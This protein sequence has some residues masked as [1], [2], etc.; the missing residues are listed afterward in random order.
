[1]RNLTAR[2]LRSRWQRLRFWL[3]FAITLLTLAWAQFTPWQH[4]AQAQNVAISAPLSTQGSTIIDTKGQPV[5]LRGVNW[6]GIET[7]THTPHG[8]WARDYKDML[9]QIADLGYNVIR[10][11][12]SVQSLRSQSISGVDFSIGSNR[13]LQG[14][15]PLQVMDIVIREAERQGLFILLDS[16]RLND[17][18][19]PVLWYGDGFTEVDWI[20]TWKMLARR[21]QNQKNVIGA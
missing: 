10:L 13:D 1:M 17:Q 8:L 6:F 5:L 7:D 14:K 20:D 2:T 12:Y 19:I 16:H 4:P 21:Y 3:Y 18:S 11:P 15:T 9:K